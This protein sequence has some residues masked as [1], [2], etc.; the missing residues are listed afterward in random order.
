MFCHFILFLCCFVL[1]PTSADLFNPTVCILGAQP[2]G[3]NGDGENPTPQ[4]T[5]PTMREGKAPICYRLLHAT[6]Q[7]FWVS[8]F[9]T[10]SHS[11]EQLFLVLTSLL[12]ELTL[13]TPPLLWSTLTSASQRKWSHQSRTCSPSC[14]HSCKYSY[15]HAILDFLSPVQMDSTFPPHFGF[16]LHP[17][18]ESFHHQL[19]P[20]FDIHL[21]FH[22][23]VGLLAILACIYT[24]VNIPLKS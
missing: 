24:Q 11:Q 10:F 4:H 1:H 15:T 16:H 7:P 20:L 14:G 8:F 21:I 6:R 9:S 2:W 22:Y 3:L 13:Q 23:P 5:G 17:P 18:P 12:R 19:S